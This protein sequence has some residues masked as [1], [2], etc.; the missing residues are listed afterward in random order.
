MNFHVLKRMNQR[1]L[2]ETKRIKN[3]LMLSLLFFIFLVISGCV[4]LD[5]SLLVDE[6]PYYGREEWMTLAYG[7]AIIFLG[8]SIKN[9]FSRLKN[10]KMLDSEGVPIQAEITGCKIFQSVDTIDYVLTYS[11]LGQYQTDAFVPK[12][13]YEKTQKGDMVAAIYLE[14]QPK[15]SRLDITSI[16]DRPAS[17]IDTKPTSFWK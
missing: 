4:Y 1:S 2:Q 10:S 8:G 17:P 5:F 7:V 14:K 3:R 6:F 12:A 11:Y 9:Q 16:P 13:I 15:I